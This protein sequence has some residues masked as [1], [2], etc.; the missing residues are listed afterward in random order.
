MKAFC[1]LTVFAALFAHAKSAI[2]LPPPPSGFTWQEI[3][4]LMTLESL[5]E[6][7]P[8]RRHLVDHATRR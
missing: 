3:P 6:E 4:E 5:D 2:D 7:E 1:L 8:Q